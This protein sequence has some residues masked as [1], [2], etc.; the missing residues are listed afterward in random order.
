MDLESERRKDLRRRTPGKVGLHGL[1]TIQLDILKLKVAHLTTM[2]S[3]VDRFGHQHCRLQKT[4]SL[5][6]ES[7]EALDCGPQSRLR[8]PIHC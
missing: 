2:V 3:L 7:A 4:E 6:C 8:L 1:N 5:L